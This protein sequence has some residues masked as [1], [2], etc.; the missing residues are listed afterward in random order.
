MLKAA[1]CCRVFVLASH[2][3]AAAMHCSK[4]LLS[5][6]ETHLRFACLFAFSLLFLTH[7]QVVDTCRAPRRP[8]L[9]Q[10]A[11]SPTEKPSSQAMPCNAFLQ[12]MRLR[13]AYALLFGP[14]MRFAQLRQGP[15][16][17]LCGAPH[18]PGPPSLSSLHRFAAQVIHALFTAGLLLCSA[19]YSVCC[20]N[21]LTRLLSGSSWSTASS[22]LTSLRTWA[23]HSLAMLRCTRCVSFPWVSALHV[24]S[25]ALLSQLSP[26][27]FSRIALHCPGSASPATQ[28]QQ[29]RH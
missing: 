7:F 2:C 5:C 8:G 21:T 10:H 25:A 1:L 24:L 16:N 28:W 4:E 20:P 26:L 27:W 14:S 18:R 12:G 9:G 13:V 19:C 23:L 6:S 11:A 29:A 3:T 22:S 15:Q 17:S